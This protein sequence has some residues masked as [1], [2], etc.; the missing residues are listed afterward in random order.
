MIQWA[1]FVS[2]QGTNL[3]NFLNLEQDKKLKQNSIVAVHADKKCPAIERAKRAKKEIFIYSPKQ[4]DYE[5]RLLEFLKQSKVDRIFLL[6]FMRIL[7]APF[8]KTWAEP[9]I[10]IHP[11]LLPKYKGLNA[12]ER[13]Y[14]DNEKLVGVSLHEVTPELDSGLVLRQSQL[15]RLESDSLESLTER[16]HQLEYKIVREYLFDLESRS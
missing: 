11:S 5:S 1:V 14:Q 4:S 12:I 2:G 6:G 13:A 7:P 3:Q 10:N 9:I 15:E 8:I 16:M